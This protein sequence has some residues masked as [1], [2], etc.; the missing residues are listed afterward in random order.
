[1]SASTTAQLEIVE[2][3][4]M[5]TGAVLI[6]CAYGILLFVP[7]F[8]S[9]LAI[10]VLPFGVLTYFIPLLAVLATIYLLPFGFGNAYVAKLVAPLTG[11][12]PKPGEGFIVQLTLTPR[13]RSGLRAM[14]EDADD[15]GY[16]SFGGEDLVFQG[17][18]VK[19]T[20]PFAQIQRVRRRRG[21]R[22]LFIYPRVAL[23]VTGLPNVTGLEFGDRSAWLLPT[24][25]KTSRKMHDRINSATAAKPQSLGAAEPQPKKM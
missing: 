13:L 7:L 20:I 19:L 25:R 10:S 18:S 2:P 22:D 21:W 5:R 1:M 8:A 16:L 6:F 9:L 15:I 12:A 14:V 17:D 24:A 4:L 11:S 3:R 23:T